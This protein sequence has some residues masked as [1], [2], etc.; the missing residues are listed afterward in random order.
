MN[1]KRINLVG[2]VVETKKGVIKFIHSTTSKGVLIS[3][4]NERYWKSAFAE[5]RRVL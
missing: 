1:K 3:S 4:L 5:A 2:L